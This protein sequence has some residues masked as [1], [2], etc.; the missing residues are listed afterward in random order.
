LQQHFLIF[1][2]FY[3]LIFIFIFIFP[4]WRSQSDDHPGTK[5]KSQI[6]LPTRYRILNQKILL[7]SLL[8]TGTYCKKKWRFGICLKIWQIWVI[9]LIYHFLK[10]S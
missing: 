4:L 3:L 7:C 10:T 2:N 1:L 8:P 9:F 6:W 5:T